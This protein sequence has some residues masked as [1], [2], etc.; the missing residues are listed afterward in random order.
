MTTNPNDR[1]PSG[2]ARAAVLSLLL[3]LTFASRAAADEKR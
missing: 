2:A 1:S 3:A